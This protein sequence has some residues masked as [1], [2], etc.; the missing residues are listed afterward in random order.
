MRFL[1][2]LPSSSKGGENVSVPASRWRIES[3]PNGESETVFHADS[4]ADVAKVVEVEAPKLDADGD[5]I[6][7]AV[8]ANDR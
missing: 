3:C 4:P 8:N 1:E 5:I 2:G 6:I 7:T